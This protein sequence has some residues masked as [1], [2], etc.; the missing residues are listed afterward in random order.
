MKYL[1]AIQNE[2]LRLNG[3]GNGIFMRQAAC[4]HYLGN[5]R[6]YQGDLVDYRVIPNNYSEK[7]YVQAHKFRP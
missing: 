6:I 4:D 2:V 5:V 7:Y 1:S 3:P